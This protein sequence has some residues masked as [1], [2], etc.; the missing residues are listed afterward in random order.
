MIMPFFGPI[1]A[2]K[3]CEV[4]NHISEI[5]LS[6]TL[7]TNQINNCLSFDFLEYTF[8]LTKYFIMFYNDSINLPNEFLSFPCRL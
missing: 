4:D 2:L 7:N 6:T 5:P 1:L 8:I 3:Q